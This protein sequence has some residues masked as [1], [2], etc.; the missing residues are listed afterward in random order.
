MTGTGTAT[1]FEKVTHWSDGLTH[2]ATNYL[3]RN[4]W[5]L[6]AKDAS[7]VTP[8]WSCNADSVM[9][10]GSKVL[11][12]RLHPPPDTRDRLMRTPSARTL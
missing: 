5:R 3:V 9:L 4:V 8:S 2:H 6:Q 12:D 7:Y 11:M 1:L 10:A